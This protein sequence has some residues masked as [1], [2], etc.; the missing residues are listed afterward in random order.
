MKKIFKL[1]NQSI[2]YTFFFLFAFFLAL[3][4]FISYKTNEYQDKILPNVF[5]D[6]KDFSGKTKEDVK[7]YFLEKNKRL[8]NS[9]ITLYYKEDVATFSGKLINLQYDSELLAEHAFLVGRTDSFL[10]KNIQKFK[11]FL[12]IEKIKFNS[13]IN[14]SE[15]E[16]KEYLEI[17]S[18]KY[19]YPAENALFKFENNKVAA[20]KIEKYGKDILKEST[21]L[22]IKSEIEKDNNGNNLSLKIEDRNIKP[23]IT[24]VEINDF[25]IKEIVGYGKSDFSGSMTERIYNVNLA[26]S[27]F[28]GILIPKG[29]TFSFNKLVGDISSTTGYKQAYIIKN[30]R[31]VLGDG[32]GVCQVSTT[33]FR[34][35]LNTGLPI[36][37]RFA[38]AYRVHYYENDA[39]PGF[40][41]TVFN[42]TNDLKFKN[43]LPSY[44]LVQT[45]ID[46]EKNLLTITFYGTK[47]NRKVTISEA[48]LWDIT[49]PPE[50]IYQDDP[51]LKN[52]IVKQVDWAAWGTKAKFNYKVVD[53]NNSILINQDFYSIYRPWANIYLRGTG[54]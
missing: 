5:I 18:D 9:Q 26:T 36:I 44:I 51:N 6:N 49:Q 22:K 50:D 47:D 53:K 54:E 41:S 42:P 23:E 1:I 48:T 12:N 2:F 27:K 40:D 32:G 35:A 34:A 38:H 8:S 31:T 45:E 24:M 33:F 21:L 19:S 37:E 43:N 30:G 13:K 39:K 17:I 7:N 16:F 29:E 20:F 28:N 14:Y 25:G 15:K 3:I 52:G 11:S 4:T 10:I 46:K